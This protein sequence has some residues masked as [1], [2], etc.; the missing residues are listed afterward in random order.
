MRRATVLAQAALLVLLVVP[1]YLAVLP[2]PLAGVVP[3]GRP[4]SVT[5][6][7]ALVA[8][9]LV[10]LVAYNSRRPDARGSDDE[11]RAVKDPEL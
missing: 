7:F 11:P 8:L 10:A 1:L 2:S 9:G 3:W 4:A 5:A 6:F